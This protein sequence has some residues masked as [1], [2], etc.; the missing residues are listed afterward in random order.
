MNLEPILQN[1]V[2]QKEKDKCCILTH[3]MKFRKIVPM[4]LH[5]SSKGDTNKWTFGLSGRRRWDDLGE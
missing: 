5:T 3:I 4:L 1:D 2:S